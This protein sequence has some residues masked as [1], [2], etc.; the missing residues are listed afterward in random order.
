VLTRFVNLG[1]RVMSHDESL[2]TTYSFNLYKK[3][4]FQHTPMMAG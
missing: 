1:D 2:H 4:D 3:G